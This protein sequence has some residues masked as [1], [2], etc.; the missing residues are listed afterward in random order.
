MFPTP[1]HT[2]KQDALM[3]VLTLLEREE[4]ANQPTEHNRGQWR[5][6]LG[7]IKPDAVWGVPTE[8][9]PGAFVRRTPK[10]REGKSHPVS[11]G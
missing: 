7:I 11:R 10:R 9:V 6:A 8:K 3:K 4:I 2:N 1:G 5:E